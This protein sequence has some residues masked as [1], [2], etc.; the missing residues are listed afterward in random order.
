MIRFDR[1]TVKAQEAV[2]RAQTLAR[3]LEHQG[4]AAIH[5][6]MALLEP[7]DGVVRTVLQRL[8]SDPDALLHD[9]REEAD[10]MT[11]FRCPSPP[12]GSWFI[13]ERDPNL[14]IDLSG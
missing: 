13:R 4:V 11:T 6:L 12:A 8:G 1:F 5:L 14:P 3:S 9:A 7:R 2:Q 10:E